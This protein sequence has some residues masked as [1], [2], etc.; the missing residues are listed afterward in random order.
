MTSD[1]KAE[2]SHLREEMEELA[3]Q[4][5]TPALDSA[6]AAAER[7]GQRFDEA[8]G[9]VR[10]HPLAAVASAAALGFL[11]GRLMGHNTYVYP[12]RAPARAGRAWRPRR[13]RLR[14]VGLLVEGDP[15][16]ERDRQ[17]L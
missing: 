2:V 1:A 10:Q 5:A 15:V 6:A 11:I 12:E 17:R 9:T 16:P 4:P 14:P 7:Y 13:T 8:L 3:H